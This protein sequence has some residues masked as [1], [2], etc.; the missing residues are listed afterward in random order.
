MSVSRVLRSTTT[1]QEAVS[2]RWHH[3]FQPLFR[4]ARL[5]P[6][7]ISGPGSA[8]S[9]STI[10][11]L[12]YPDTKALQKRMATVAPAIPLNS[13]SESPHFNI[14]SAQFI[15]KLYTLKIR[16][17]SSVQLRISPAQIRTSSACFR[18]DKP[19]GTS[20]FSPEYICITHPG[21]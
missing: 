4:R 13:R 10:Q 20:T 8:P 21:N 3:S 5:A 7:T 2:A 15:S 18:L 14:A 16:L 12:L 19:T 9:R 17:F 1:F 6:R 11:P